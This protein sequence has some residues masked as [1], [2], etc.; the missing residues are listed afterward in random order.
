MQLAFLNERLV[1]HVV[2]PAR[3]KGTAGTTFARRGPKLAGAAIR[4]VGGA[5]AILRGR[6]GIIGR[7]GR[8]IPVWSPV[9]VRRTCALGSCFS[10]AIFA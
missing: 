2:E 1:F 8:W 3:P 9:A 6:T 4:G 10:R 5:E 7:W